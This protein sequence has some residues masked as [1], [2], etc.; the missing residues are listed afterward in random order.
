MHIKLLWFLCIAIIPRAILCIPTVLPH[1][2]SGS[3]GHLASSA[4]NKHANTIAHSAVLSH[5]ANIISSHAVKAI[6]AHASHTPVQHIQNPTTV[7]SG[8]IIQSHSTNVAHSANVAN[9]GNHLVSSAHQNHLA[10]SSSHGSISHGTGDSTK[11]ALIHHGL[12]HNAHHPLSYSFAE[13]TSGKGISTLG[14]APS[15]SVVTN[16]RSN[17]IL[18]ANIISV[19]LT[20]I[21]IAVSITGISFTIYHTTKSR[22]SRKP[23]YVR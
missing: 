5:T 17:S 8:N 13:S 21:Q 12:Q 22:R 7:H 11:F 23:Y 6:V 18:T 16:T 14:K 3:L 15:T 19:V 1:V 20:G 2:I 10:A 4:I 9:F